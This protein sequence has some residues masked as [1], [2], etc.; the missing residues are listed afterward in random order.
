MADEQEPEP[1]KPAQG[2]SF[3]DG[4]TIHEAQTDA[5]PLILTG[6]TVIIRVGKPLLHGQPPQITWEVIGLDELGTQAVCLA[7]AME[8]NQGWRRQSEQLQAQRNAQQG[9]IDPR[10]RGNG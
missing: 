5:V 6:P 4:A 3:G 7:V 1:D 9:I 10:N 8:F 2:E